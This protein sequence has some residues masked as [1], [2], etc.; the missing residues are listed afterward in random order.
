MEL[1]LLRRGDA[2]DETRVRLEHI[3]VVF[4]IIDLEGLASDTSWE[5]T[6]NVLT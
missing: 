6:H 3:K 2:R 4:I 5:G 1:L